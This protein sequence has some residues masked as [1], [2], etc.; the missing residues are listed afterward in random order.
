LDFASTLAGHNSTTGFP[1]C[2]SSYDATISPHFKYSPISTGTILDIGGYLGMPISMIVH[3]YQSGYERISTC[4]SC[5]SEQ[6]AISA[7]EYY[8][9]RD[10]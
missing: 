4:K 9:F 2:I 7:T 10:P 5:R 6:Y 8:T 1:E 3:N